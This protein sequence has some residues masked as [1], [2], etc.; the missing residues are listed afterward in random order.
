MCYNVIDLFVVPTWPQDTE[1][2][3]GIALGLKKKEKQ[4]KK[5]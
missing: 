4:E 1:A 5:E 3:I 2:M